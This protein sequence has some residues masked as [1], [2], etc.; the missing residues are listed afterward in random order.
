MNGAFM[1][2]LY[3]MYELDCTGFSGTSL[4]G[5]AKTTAAMTRHG[6]QAETFRLMRA[7][8]QA[9]CL[10]AKG[11]LTQISRACGSASDRP[12][13]EDE[14]QEQKWLFEAAASGLFTS[15]WHL[16]EFS[17]SL[18]SKLGT[19]FVYAEAL[20]DRYRPSVSPRGWSRAI[21]Q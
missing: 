20:V 17:S 12:W 13:F 21:W 3:R 9:S 4:F 16:R 5:L 15:L 6:F 18:N 2:I 14:N 19:N 8:A 1:S 11:L 10:A 7:A